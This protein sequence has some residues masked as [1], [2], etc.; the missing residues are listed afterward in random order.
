MGN[1]FL[2]LFDTILNRIENSN[3]SF[4]VEKALSNLARELDISPDVIQ[5]ALYCDRKL[6]V[7]EPEP[8]L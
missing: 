5:L 3:D 1:N 2:A 6:V 7:H 8:T 4:R